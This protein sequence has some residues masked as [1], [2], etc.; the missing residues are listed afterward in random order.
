MAV[1]PPFALSNMPSSRQHEVRIHGY[2][3][4]TCR[5]AD[6]SLIVEWLTEHEGR[7]ATVARSAFKKKSTFAG[8]L[9]ILFYAAISYRRSRKSDLHTLK[10]IELKTTPRRIRRSAASLEQIAYFVEL[11]QRTTEPETPIPEVFQL[12]HQ[13]LNCTEQGACGAAF[14]LWFEWQLLKILGLQP[15]VSAIRLDAKCRQTLVLWNR[16]SKDFPA[17]TLLDKQQTATIGRLLAKLWSG[18]I[19]R[20]PQA[21]NRLLS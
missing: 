18:E 10:E 8:K 14:T 9:D 19:G 15:A 3:I 6:T 21:R 20:C 1:T 7:I 4:R 13:T 2:I 11:I 12:F 16:Q 17:E 5:L